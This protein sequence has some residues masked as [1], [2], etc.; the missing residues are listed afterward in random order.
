MGIARDLA[1]F[2]KALRKDVQADPFTLRGQELLQS[3]PEAQHLEEQIA[4]AGTQTPVGTLLLG[5]QALRI[6]H[7]ENEPRLIEAELVATLPDASPRQARATQQVIWQM[8]RSARSEI[9][10]LGYQL[11]SRDLIQLLSDAAERGVDVFLICNDS[12]TVLRRVSEGWSTHAQAPRVFELGHRGQR[13]D[14]PFASMHAK[15]LLV[16]HIDLLIT[17]ANFTFHGLHGNIEL[18]VRLKGP[19]VREARD[20]FSY[21]VTSGMVEEV[22]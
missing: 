3:R 4:A 7:T 18:G 21:L 13:D 20:V 9:I 1:E 15:S 2:E 12:A 11:T 8:V 6:Q 14:I 16:D 22:G 10:L 5:L 17:S 19:P